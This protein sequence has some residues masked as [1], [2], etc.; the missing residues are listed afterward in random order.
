MSITKI[1]NLDEIT[2]W[3]DESKDILEDIEEN[4]S[5]ATSLEWLWDITV[6]LTEVELVFSWVTKTIR[7]QAD[8]GNTGIIYIG[9]TWVLSDWSNDFQRLSPWD[10]VSFDYNDSTNAIY[11]ISD[12]ASQ[13]INVWALIQ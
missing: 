11:V 12:T 6:W 13:T 9:N 4:N 8:S 7:I 3:Q 5:V 2:Q 10:E 1:S